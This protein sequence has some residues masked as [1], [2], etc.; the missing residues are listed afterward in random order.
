M[1]NP[2]RWRVIFYSPSSVSAGL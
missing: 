1:V 2:K